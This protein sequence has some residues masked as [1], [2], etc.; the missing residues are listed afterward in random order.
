VS[1][2]DIRAAIAT[3]IASRP[4]LRDDKPREAEVIGKNEINIYWV[5]PKATYGGHY[6]IKRVH[7]RWRYDL[8]VI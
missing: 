8:R 1:T 4:D 5:A 7:G 2:A 6:I 3:V